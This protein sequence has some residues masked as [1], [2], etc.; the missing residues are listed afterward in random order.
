M[1]DF[2]E[3]YGLE[4]IFMINRLTSTYSSPLIT[5]PRSLSGGRFVNC[6]WLYIQSGRIMRLVSLTK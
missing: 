1:E 4:E 5:L 6:S 2:R 3:L